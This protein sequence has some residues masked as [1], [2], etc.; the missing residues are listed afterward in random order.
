MKGEYDDQLEWPFR[1]RV[2]IRMRNQLAP[3]THIVGMFEF[4]EFI[5][6]DACARVTGPEDYAPIGLGNHL[7]A[8][9]A[10]MEYD[11]TRNRQ[12]LKN[13]CIELEVCDIRVGLNDY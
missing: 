1:G 3:T 5:R 7:F 4:D 6:Q 13:D 12:Y 8:S 9:H 10:D 2:T 11:M